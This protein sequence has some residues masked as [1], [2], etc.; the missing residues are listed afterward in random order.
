MADNAKINCPI[1]KNGILEDK[2]LDYRTTVKE[3]N[4]YGPMVISKLAV[5]CC[6]NCQEVFLPKNSLEKVYSE[7]HKMRGILL[8][9]ELRRIRQDLGLTQSQ[10]SGL[11]GIGK[12]SYLRWEKGASLQSRSMD[13]YIRLLAAH[14]DNVLFLKKL[15]NNGS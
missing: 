7:K 9:E 10:M 11:L 3:G 12:K 8:P 6:P 1:C 15:C 5:E 2:I 4:S 14:P 13:R